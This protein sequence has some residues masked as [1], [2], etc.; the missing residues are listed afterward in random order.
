MHIFLDLIG[1]PLQRP[2]SWPLRHLQLIPDNAEKVLAYHSSLQHSCHRFLRFFGDCSYPLASLESVIYLQYF[3]VNGSQMK[4]FCLIMMKYR[5]IQQYKILFQQNFI[6][7]KK[8]FDFLDRPRLLADTVYPQSS[9]Q[10]LTATYT[11][12]LYLV[13][14]TQKRQ[15]KFPMSL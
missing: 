12:S 6:T 7:G 11:K 2:S 8:I 5:P 1:W 9:P 3:Y 14:Y 13:L 15:D 4:S 10:Q